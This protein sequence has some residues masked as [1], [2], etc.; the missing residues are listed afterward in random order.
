MLRDIP[1]VLQG[2]Y[3]GVEQMDL[4]GI[5]CGKRGPQWP[6]HLDMLSGMANWHFVTKDVGRRRRRTGG[7]SNRHAGASLLKELRMQ[8]KKTSKGVLGRKYPDT[9]A[10][11]ANLA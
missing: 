11:M 7:A 8:V 4:I 2:S 10:G 5:E 1:I 6:K 9:L 3:V